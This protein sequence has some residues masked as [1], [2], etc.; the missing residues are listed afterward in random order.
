[1]VAIFA[2]GDAEYSKM[3]YTC[4]ETIKKMNNAY[5]PVSQKCLAGLLHHC[6]ARPKW[7]ICSTSYGKFDA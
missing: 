3:D 2:E 4:H 5:N 6:T 1:V 7:V